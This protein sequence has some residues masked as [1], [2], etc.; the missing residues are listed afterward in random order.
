MRQFS[1]PKY[2][3][4]RVTPEQFGYKDRGIL[5]WQG[6]ILSDHT[7][8]LKREK[9]N[10]HLSEV[11][12]KEGMS[13][14]GISEALY[15][16]FVTATPVLIQANVINN[17]RYYNDLECIILGYEDNQIYLKL[18]DG[19][20]TNCTLDQIRNVEYMDMLKWFDKV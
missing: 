12:A 3:I 14:E 1:I 5:K 20:T 19:R 7:D 13:E 17:G 2:N 8:A 10:E 11:E 16:A 4:I 18:K 6:M 9:L 15:N